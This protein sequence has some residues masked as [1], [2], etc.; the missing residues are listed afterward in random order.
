M[1]DA[2]RGLALV[3]GASSGIGQ[4]FA[5]RLAAEGVPLLLVARREERLRDLATD[6]AARYGVQAGFA[7]ADLATEEGRR[8]CRD[9]V[10]AVGGIVDTVV[11]NAGFGAMGTVAEIGRERQAAMVALNCECVVDLAC[12][13]L[14]GMIDRGR[15]TVIVVSSAAAWQPIPYM[16]TYGA[17]KAFELAFADALAVELAGTGVRSIAVC[18]GPTATE[19]SAAAGTSY[20]AGWLPR[21]TADDV[22]AATWRALERGRPRVATGWLSRVTT[23][24]ASVLP[25]RLV[26]W[27]AGAVHRR[28]RPHGAD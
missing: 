20:G 16:A 25:R 5:E 10:N 11:L 13:V 21:E 7:V 18:P 19:F 15:G 23:I 4:A 22:V 3:T 1:T 9:A 14:P 28:F 6:L 2:G 24:A 8:T 27:G 12:H 17:T 26:I